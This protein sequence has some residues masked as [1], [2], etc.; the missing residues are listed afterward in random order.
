M[1][2]EHEDGGHLVA[3]LGS[4][5][6]RTSVTYFIHLMSSGRFGGDSVTVGLRRGKKD[7]LFLRSEVL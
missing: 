3:V 7:T 6:R 1:D 5:G 4:L 2:E